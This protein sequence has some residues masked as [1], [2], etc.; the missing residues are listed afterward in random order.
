[1]GGTTGRTP[2]RPE[3]VGEH[4]VVGDR[5]A[6]FGEQKCLDTVVFVHGLGGDFL[7][8]WNRFP[9]LL[10]SDPDLPKLDLFL[11]GYDSGV[12][13]PGIA[14]IETVGGQLMSELF[15]RFER[16]NAVHL[17]GHSLGGLVILKGIVS[18][19]IAMRAQER[20]TSHVSF[21]SLF[22]A[23]VSGSSVAAILKR[24]LGQLPG[25]GSLLNHQLRQVA[26]GIDVDSLLNEVFSR[27]YAPEK[28]DASR[29][30][31]PI[32]M[33]MAIRDGIVDE[34]DRQR[35]SARFQKL[36]PLSFDYDHVTIK[37]PNDHDDNRYRALAEDVQDGLRKRFQDICVDL[38]SDSEDAK[39]AAATEFTRRYEHLFRCRLEN[40]GVDVDSEQEI[41]RS[42]LNVIIDDCRR[43][44]RPPHFAANLALKHL[45]EQR[46]IP[47]GR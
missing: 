19:M 28:P 47:R 11:W 18:E 3:K 44:G 38:N 43:T 12:F 22:A 17:V 8:T 42:Y 2:A 15:V 13:K 9:D 21:I 4:H 25:L 7:K 34:T 27:V 6:F 1:M 40:A 30:V 24:T 33:V 31:I 37:E 46:L 41:Y 45:I 36:M 14:S 39:A 23:P 10:A 32:R 35:A 5:A 26:R 20:P 29:R 16:D